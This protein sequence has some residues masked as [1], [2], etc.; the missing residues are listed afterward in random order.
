M[1]R[2][3]FGILLLQINICGKYIES[4]IAACYSVRHC[5]SDICCTRTW[6]PG[7]GGRVQSCGI[8]QAWAWW[9]GGHTASWVFCRVELELMPGVDRTNQGRAQA[10]S[11]HAKQSIRGAWVEGICRGALP[12]IQQQSHDITWAGKPSGRNAVPWRR[13]HEAFSYVTV[14]QNG[15]TQ[16]SRVWKQEC[17]CLIAS[18][19]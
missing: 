14:F 12:W 3:N 13:R 7:P 1:T 8:H 19:D 16:S 15:Q 17:G 2:K 9:E 18:L 4:V 5:G 10:S 11:M 6:S